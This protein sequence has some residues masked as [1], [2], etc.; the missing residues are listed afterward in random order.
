MSSNQLRN[1]MRKSLKL[2]LNLGACLIVVEEHPSFSEAKFPVCSLISAFLFLSTWPHS[3]AAARV[4][5]LEIEYNID[6]DDIREADL[7]DTLQIHSMIR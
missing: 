1:V 2:N 6:R 3:F 5:L 7:R 4:L